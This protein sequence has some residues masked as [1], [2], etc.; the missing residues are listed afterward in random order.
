MAVVQKEVQGFIQ[1]LSKGN[2]VDLAVATIV[3][4]SFSSI[5]DALTKDVLGP[6][7]DLL[8]PTTMQNSFYILRA[9]PNGPYENKAEAIE[10]G[11]AVISYGTFLQA[12][13]NFVLKGLCLFLLVRVISKM[14]SLKNLKFM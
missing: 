14:Q 11:A 12:C 5:V 8:T 6:V 9:G 2:V 4:G 3:G 10:D 13:V 1:F 7:L